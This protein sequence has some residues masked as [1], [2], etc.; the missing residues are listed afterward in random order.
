LSSF[1]YSQVS[2][3]Q[4]T[5]RK[6]F[7]KQEGTP[8]VAPAPSAVKEKP[9][10]KKPLQGLPIFEYQDRGFKWAV[11][12]H[13]VDSAM[14]E[15]SKEGVITI[16]ISDPKQQVYVYNCDGITIKVNGKFKSLILDQCEGCAVVYDTLISSTEVVNSKNIQLQVIG[17]CP[18]FTIDKTNKVMIYLSKE[19]LAVTNFSTSLSSEMNVSFPD[20]DE[21]KELP[22]PEQYV[23]KLVGGV[24]KSQV[25]DLYT[26]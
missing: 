21:Q 17:V 11:E 5:W 13:T 26:H 12:N 4:Q 3:D 7:K 23:H 15:V 18:V 6:E 25:S 20:G 9:K 8:P 24:L 2:K 19:S 1:T 14:K 16:E 10:K 22:I